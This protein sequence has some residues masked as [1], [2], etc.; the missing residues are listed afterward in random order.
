MREMLSRVTF[1]AAKL[2]ALPKFGP[3]ELN[4]AAVVDRQV[5]TDA[6]IKDLSDTVQQLVATQAGAG[7]TTLVSAAHHVIQSTVADMQ[8][9]LDS[10]ASSVFARLNHLN[11]CH[12]TLNSN[13]NNQ[14]DRIVQQPVVADR[15]LNIVIFG[16]SE[17]RDALLW[18]RKIDDILR[19]IT[20]HSVDVVDMFRLGRCL[21]NKTR[22]VLVELRTVWD[23]R[24]ILSRC[25]KLKQY[26]QRGVYVAPDEPIEVRRKNLL[27]KLKYRAQHA[28]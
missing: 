21:S 18:R 23:K 11:T 10:F 2:D 26:S 1:V 27:D 24:L 19:F 22:P 9:K 20:D 17:E 13:S 3:E 14:Q 28:G 4:V 7:S 16:V 8:Q 12:G 5:H 6:T 15:K 25:S